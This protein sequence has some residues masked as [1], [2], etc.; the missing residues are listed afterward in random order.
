MVPGYPIQTIEVVMNL[1][2]TH[3][4]WMVALTLG[5]VLVILA[6]MMAGAHAQCAP[7]DLNCMNLP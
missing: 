4:L 1:T 5:G 7:W 2:R 3:I 6:V